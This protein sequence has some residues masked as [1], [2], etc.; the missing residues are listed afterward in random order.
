MKVRVNPHS[1]ELIYLEGE[2]ERE[3]QVLKDMWEHGVVA[4]SASGGRELGI[5]SK[6]FFGSGSHGSE[7]LRSS[8]DTAEES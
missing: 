3:R 4:A 2:T 1:D 6:K 7:I 8:E 5:C